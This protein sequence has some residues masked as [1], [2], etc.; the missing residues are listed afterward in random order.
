MAALRHAAAGEE[1]EDMAAELGVCGDMNAEA[2]SGVAACGGAA[3]DCSVAG[4]ERGGD[5]ARRFCKKVIRFVRN[6]R[7]V[8]RFVKCW[9]AGAISEKDRSFFV[10]RPRGRLR[11]PLDRESTARTEA[12]TVVP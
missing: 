1:G 12:C 6:Y 10:K 2:W 3:G 8:P 9:T 5:A 4:E 11:W 7:K